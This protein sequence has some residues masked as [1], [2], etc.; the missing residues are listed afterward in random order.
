MPA[1]F[2][3]HSVQQ[4]GVSMDLFFMVP[5]STTELY[6]IEA[7]GERTSLRDVRPHFG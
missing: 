4:A 1:L 7:V 5:A 6:Q 3:V 2:F